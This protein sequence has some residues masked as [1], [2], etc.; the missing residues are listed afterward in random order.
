MS[1]LQINS[2]TNFILHRAPNSDIPIC[3]ATWEEKLRNVGIPH[4]VLENIVKISA[5]RA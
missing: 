2:I 4:I 3:F 5:P 1:A